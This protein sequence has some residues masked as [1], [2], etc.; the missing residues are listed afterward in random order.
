MCIRDRGTEQLHYGPL[1]PSEESLML[2]G[3]V[4]G[5]KILELGSGAGQNS[6]VLAK[7]GA[8]CTAVDISDKQLEHGRQMADSEGQSVRFIRS[9][10]TSFENLFSKEEFDIALSVY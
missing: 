10:F 7:Q 4:T 8:D 6:I 9:N 2:L 5:K 3:E 1:C